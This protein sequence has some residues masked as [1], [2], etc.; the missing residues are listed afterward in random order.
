MADPEI[1]N[2]LKQIAE[3][4]EDLT[5]RMVFADWLQDRGYPEAEAVRVGDAEAALCEMPLQR[6]ALNNTETI[7]L[8]VPAHICRPIC[9]SWLKLVPV[10]GLWFSLD[11]ITVTT[12]APD[13]FKCWLMCKVEGRFDS[14]CYRPFSVDGY[15]SYKFSLKEKAVYGDH[16]LWL[17]SAKETQITVSAV[18]R[19][20][21][22]V[23]SPILDDE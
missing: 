18:V 9:R 4:P 6:I 7:K 22:T 8:T 19:S 10:E 16:W 23:W 11:R 17:H 1:E 13:F 15:S 2:W 14:V 20:Q 3:S 21:R 12:A 5:L